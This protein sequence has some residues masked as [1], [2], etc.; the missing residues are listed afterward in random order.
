[1][2]I[3]SKIADHVFLSLIILLFKTCKSSIIKPLLKSK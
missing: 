1:M 3:C 2:E